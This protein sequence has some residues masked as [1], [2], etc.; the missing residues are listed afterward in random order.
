MNAVTRQLVT[1]RH[2]GAVQTQNVE[3]LRIQ[4]LLMY[5]SDMCVIVTMVTKLLQPTIAVFTCAQISMSVLPQM[6]KKCIIVIQETLELKPRRNVKTLKAITHVF[7]LMGSSMQTEMDTIA[8]LK[9][10]TLARMKTNAKVV[11]STLVS[12]DHLQLIFPTHLSRALIKTLRFQMIDLFVPVIPDMN[13]LNHWKVKHLT[14]ALTSM[15]V[16]VQISVTLPTVVSVIIQFGFKTNFTLLM[17]SF[18]L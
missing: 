7:V 16:T 15:N 10:V 8:P 11:H 18:F 14:V 13:S 9:A 4:I 12:R 3:I 17:I 5:L 1:M 2:I 6:W